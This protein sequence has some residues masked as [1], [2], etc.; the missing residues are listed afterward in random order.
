[1]PDAVL[2]EQAYATGFIEGYA[3]GKE[4]GE[5]NFQVQIAKAEA[6]AARTTR[7]ISIESYEV[8]YQ[9]AMQD[10][11]ARSLFNRIFNKD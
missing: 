8:G 1:M 3:K 5:L 4:L 10:H 6:Q 7:S 2:I 11:K 9:Q